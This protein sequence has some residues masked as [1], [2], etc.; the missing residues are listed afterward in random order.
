MFKLTKL[1]FY[2][3][4]F[5]IFFAI[6]A[7]IKFHSNCFVCLCHGAAGLPLF[8]PGI[9]PDLQPVYQVSN[10]RKNPVIDTD[11]HHT[12]TLCVFPPVWRTHSEISASDSTCF[13]VHQRGEG[14]ESSGGVR[15]GPAVRLVGRSRSAAGEFTPSRFHD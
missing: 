11:T 15:L 7:K 13:V 1:S 2:L 9:L 4:N 12:I 3:I 8:F 6:S 5:S 14:A 10:H